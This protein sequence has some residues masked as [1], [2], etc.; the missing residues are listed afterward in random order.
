MDVDRFKGDIDALQDG[1]K[2]RRKKNPRRKKI[3]EKAKRLCKKKSMDCVEEVLGNLT[4]KILKYKKN[5]N[6]RKTKKKW[7]GP[8]ARNR[9]QQNS[10]K[11]NYIGM[12][13]K[14]YGI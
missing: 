3:K 5:Q 9:E 10:Q 2:E 4:K 8:Q 13:N 6:E 12:E 11:I 7:D 14:T 1:D